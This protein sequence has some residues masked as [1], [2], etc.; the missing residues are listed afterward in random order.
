MTGVPIVLSGPSGVGKNTVI[1]AVMARDPSFVY[2]VSTTTR[3]PRPGE[4][5]GQPYHFVSRADFERGIAAGR[6]VEYATVYG[7][8]YGTDR[9]RLESALAAGRDVLLDIDTQGAAQ[10][11]RACPASVRIYLLPPSTAE[12]E[13]RLRSRKTDNDEEIRRRLV[14]FDD[15]RRQIGT[16]THIVINDDVECAAEAV[17]AIARADRCRRERA[18]PVLEA[19]GWTFD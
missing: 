10:L 3:P 19:G 7:H 17:R 6:F 5:E 16:Y 4:R 11:A 2:S 14:E 13:R 12:L 1:R 8:Y 15:E 9:G 18:R